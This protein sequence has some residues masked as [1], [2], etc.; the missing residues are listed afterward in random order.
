VG[1]EIILNPSL[2]CEIKMYRVYRNDNGVGV[3]E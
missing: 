3:L 1:K 2:V